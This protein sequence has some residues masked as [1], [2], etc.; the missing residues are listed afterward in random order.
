LGVIESPYR[1]NSKRA[2]IINSSQ[3]F[4]HVAV[5]TDLGYFFLDCVD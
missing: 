5:A 3:Q 1:D 2:N 4:D